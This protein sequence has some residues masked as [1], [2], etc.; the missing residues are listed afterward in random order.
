MRIS[1]WS[2]DVC[3]SDLHS[4]PTSS[5]SSSTLTLPTHSLRERRD[6]TGC[7]L[8][9]RGNICAGQSSAGGEV[10][11]TMASMIKGREIGYGEEADHDSG[12]VCSS[13]GCNS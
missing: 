1:D 12:C 10:K 13:D 9:G 5:P 2:S 7:R 4:P 11:R 3:S 8:R 6:I